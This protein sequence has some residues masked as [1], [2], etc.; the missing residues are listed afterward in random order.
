[1]KNKKSELYQ[2]WESYGK[3]K[4]LVH[5]D[6][7]LSF[8]ED[9]ITATKGNLNTDY[10]SGG[11]SD[12]LHSVKKEGDYFY[13]YWK[14]FEDA[15]NDPSQYEEI[16][17]FGNHIYIYQVVDISS[18]IFLTHN[19]SLLII[20][21]S[22]YLSIREIKKEISK[23]HK[24]KKEDIFVLDE[25]LHW[26]EFLFKDLNNY[27]HSCQLIPFPINS[28]LIQDKINP[29][30]E[31]I[32]EKIMHRH[33]YM[34]F[35]NKLQ[36]WRNDVSKLIDF[37]NE[38]EIKN[39][40][41]EI[42]SETERILKYYILKNAHYSNENHEELE[43]FYKDLLEKYNH[44]MLGN[45][46]DMLKVANKDFDLPS[47]VVTTLN[48]LSHDSGKVAYKEDINLVLDYYEKIIDNYLTL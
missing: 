21:K 42:R 31:Q 38:R 4:Q 27:N 37:E 44:T 29:I 20:V 24:I 36:N 32:S 28:L 11:Y 10:Y 39:L 12:S 47:N 16:A 23:K 34:E 7:I 48:K 6:E 8:L 2:V 5:P 14:N 30:D 45:L 35:F 1:M 25:A 13:L 3:P 19:N 46:K 9:I 43:P 33:T 41:N 26:V 22:R 18:L 15:V 17:I 40:G